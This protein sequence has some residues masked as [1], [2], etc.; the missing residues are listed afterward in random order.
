[1]KLIHYISNSLATLAAVCALA[2]CSNID[3]D[4]RLIEVEAPTVSKNV[5]I[6]DY[7]GQLCSNCPNATETIH[8]LQTD[9]GDDRVIAVGIYSGKFGY[10]R[11][12]KPL[13]LTTEAG[14]NYAVAWGVDGQP[15]GVID[16]QGR[17]ESYGTWRK[18]VEERLQIQTPVKMDASLMVMGGKVIMTIHT[19]CTKSLTDT[20]IMAWLM[21]DSIVSPQV[22]PT[23]KTNSTYIHNHVFR[24]TLSPAEGEV[25]DLTADENHRTNT[26]TLD[27]DPAWVT[28][29]LTA[30]AFVY[31]KNG[32][33]Q[34]V[35]ANTGDYSE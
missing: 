14:N 29:H 23:G 11:Q 18:T 20:R 33:Q 24:Q 10:N 1:M 27:V 2:S 5:L 31:D 35:K 12:G 21:E 25:I 4:K 9:Y 34:V 32:V 7:T 16:R 17:N 19:A 8:E 22:M 13:P 3:E 15:C 26:Y 30:V 6:E 28:K